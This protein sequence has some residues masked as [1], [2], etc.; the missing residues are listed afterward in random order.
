[1]Q[2]HLLNGQIWSYVTPP[3]TGVPFQKGWRVPRILSVKKG[4]YPHVC[5]LDIRW[6]KQTP[7]WEPYGFF[8]EWVGLLCKW[9][10]PS[11]LTGL[12]GFN[13][14]IRAISLAIFTEKIVS[15]W[16]KILIIQDDVIPKISIQ[17]IKEIHNIHSRRV[18]LVQPDAWIWLPNNKK[19]S[20]AISFLF[21]NEAFIYAERI[22]SR[23]WQLYVITRQNTS[24]PQTTNALFWQDSSQRVL[25]ISLCII[26]SKEPTEWV[27]N[28]PSSSSRLNQDLKKTSGMNNLI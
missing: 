12:I 14:M 4:E 13:Q 5:Y 27:I 25:S 19:S 24:S 8:I 28:T 10:P 7:Y 3:K 21:G 2:V 15:F 20:R 1:M 23:N 16:R 26:T 18:I 22:M 11:F 17:A 6:R 9:I